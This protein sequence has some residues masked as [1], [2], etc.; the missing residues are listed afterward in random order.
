MLA[1][2][3]SPYCKTLILKGVHQVEKVNFMQVDPMSFNEFLLGALP[4]VEEDEIVHSLW[5]IYEYHKAVEI[6]IRFINFHKT[7]D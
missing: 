7:V 6:L 3:N 1:W 5:T 4:S 2:K